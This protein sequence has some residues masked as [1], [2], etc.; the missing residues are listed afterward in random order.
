MWLLQ[1]TGGSSDSLRRPAMCW[2]ASS[3]GVVG[4]GGATDAGSRPLVSFWG[5]E[6]S[7]AEELC[8]T[9]S[10]H[11]CSFDCKC[12][13]TFCQVPLPRSAV[14]SCYYSGPESGGQIDRPSPMGRT[15]L[16]VH[17]TRSDPEDP[18]LNKSH[19]SQ[20]PSYRERM[21]SCRV[22]IQYK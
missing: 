10:C 17:K 22:H 13:G 20:C 14:G 9:S 16:T 4:T 21:I 15:S 6:G 7:R 3:C 18:E 19:L 5:A 1:P 2:S 11:H 12:V 8:H